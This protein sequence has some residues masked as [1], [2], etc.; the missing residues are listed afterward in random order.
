MPRNHKKKQ[1]IDKS[2]AKT[3]TVFH[4]SEPDPRFEHQKIATPHGIERVYKPPEDGEEHQ[5]DGEMEDYYEQ[6]DDDSYED[7]ELNFT[8]SIGAPGGVFVSKSGHVMPSEEALVKEHM[9]DIPE[10]NDDDHAIDAKL[11]D[12][13]EA[14]PDIVAALLRAEQGA[15]ADDNQGDGGDLTDDFVALALLDDVELID[16]LNHPTIVVDGSYG[17]YDDIDDDADDA[18][19]GDADNGDA[20]SNDDDHG[21]TTTTT[22]ST[23]DEIPQE[24]AKLMQHH[25][26][27]S[28]PKATIVDEMFDAELKKFDEDE[29]SATRFRGTP[30]SA[31]DILT[32]DEDLFEDDPALDTGASG[33]YST[34]TFETVFDDFLDDSIRVKY[35]PP[36]RQELPEP[37]VGTEE[38]D[39]DEQALVEIF[40]KEKRSEWDVESI[41]STYSNTDNHPKL[42]VAEIDHSK[43][44]KLRRGMPDIF[45]AEKQRDETESQESEPNLGQARPKDETQEMKKLRKQQVKA[46]KKANRERKKELKT[47]YKQEEIR[48]RNQHATGTGALM[49]RTIVQY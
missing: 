46:Q 47:T 13:N 49:N 42:I 5:D 16:N 41:V 9:L 27:T 43:R 35:V 12:D 40:I 1:W 48:L 44:I 2:N 3:Y 32:D 20:V 4:K 10:E 37:L 31:M 14:D 17:K 33:P 11:L 30:V 23:H 7:S 21:T 29:A 39:E 8:R 24:I 22:T 45:T 15:E 19:D 25:A 28:A 26:T 18:D 34:S 6:D 36:P 38:S